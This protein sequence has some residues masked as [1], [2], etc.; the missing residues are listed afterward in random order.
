MS[1]KASRQRNSEAYFRLRA[2]KLA[3]KEATLSH[4]LTPERAFKLV[5][6]RVAWLSDKIQ[7]Y[8]V[9]N[10]SCSHFEEEIEAYYWMMDKIK[11][12]CSDLLLK[13]EEIIN[14]KEEEASIRRSYS[15][16]MQDVQEFG[17]EKNPTAMATK[18]PSSP[19][20][21]AQ[22]EG[23]RLGMSRVN[24][25]INELKENLD[26]ELDRIWNSTLETR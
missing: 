17:K 5:T 23:A 15:S 14:L 9:N 21:L 1:G 24:K 16:Y 4:N 13:E 6:N 11:E 3:R 26:D 7:W 19:N 18:L 20:Y 8:K 2:E 25:S 22:S 10:K 12:L